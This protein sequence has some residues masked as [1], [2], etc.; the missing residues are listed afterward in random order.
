[1]KNNY[2]IVNRT[3]HLGQVFNTESDMF[4]H[5]GIPESI[6]KSRLKNGWS[7]EKTLTTPPANNKIIN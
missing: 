4:K 3:D 1:M 2:D 7:I 6:G 5:W